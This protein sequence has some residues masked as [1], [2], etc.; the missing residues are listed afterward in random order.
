MRAV[1]FISSLVRHGAFRHYY[2][3]HQVSVSEN[4]CE[5]NLKI[6]YLPLDGHVSPLLVTHHR[7][8][9]IIGPKLY[10]CQQFPNK[11]ITIVSY[12]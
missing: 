5:W 8:N 9:T 2:F 12:E 1:R 4:Q 6:T 3:V 11:V 10:I 7:I